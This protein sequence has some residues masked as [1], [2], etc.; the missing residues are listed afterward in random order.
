VYL[1]WGEPFADVGAKI[2]WM[3]R[4]A[5]QVG[6]TLRFGIRLHVITRDTAEAAWAEAQRLLEG[7]DPEAIRKIQAG[8]ARSES[9]GQKRMIALHKGSTANLEVAPNLWAGIG[10]V[11]GGAGTALVGSHTEVAAR[12]KEYADLGITEFILSGIPHLEEAYWFGE[13][14]LPQLQRDGLWSHPRGS[15][16]RSV[17]GTV[18]V[19]FSPAAT[20]AA[21]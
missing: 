7:I 4:E 9:I 3:R 12:I 16:A 19:P 11:R 6:R 10:L 1:T 5:K 8:L 2:D 18:D 21:Q 14:V 20:R 17:L 13:G 15:E